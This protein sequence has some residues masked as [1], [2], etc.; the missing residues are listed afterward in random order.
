MGAWVAGDARTNSPFSATVQLYTDETTVAGA[1]AYASSYP[2]V[3]EYVSPSEIIFTGTPWYEITLVHEDGNTFETIESGGTFLLPCSYTVS[4]FTDATGA[5]G[6]ISC[7]PS[8]IYNLTVSAT[9]YCTGDVVTFALDNTTS[10]RTYQLYKDGAE[11][12]EL[13][14]TDAGATFTGTFAG[15]GTYAAQVKDNGTYCAAQMSGT[16]VVSE[17]PVPDAPATGGSGTFCSIAGSTITAMPG[18]GG[19]GI[20]WTDNSNTDSPR[21]VTASGTYYAVTTSAGGCESSAAS[22]SVSIG[23]PGAV[24]QPADPTCGCVSGT[25][26][27]G[28]TC[29]TEAYTYSVGAC[30]RCLVAWMIQKDACGNVVNSKHHEEVVNPLCWTPGVCYPDYTASCSSNP[31]PI[32]VESTSNCGVACADLGRTR[33]YHYY[34]V[35]CSGTPGLTDCR[36]NCICYFCN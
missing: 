3:G 32:T 2:P 26:N 6:K 12:D 28:N 17:N 8:D 19:N 29:K 14:G 30:S 4:S 20:R 34:Y 13:T 33:Q 5:P 1:C 10:G 9:N 21:T 22:V 36:T 25:V 7:I 24:N 15:A 18:S 35:Q 16:Y 11:V 23:T 27:C 31:T